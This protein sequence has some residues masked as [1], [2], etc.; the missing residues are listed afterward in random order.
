MERKLG[1]MLVKD[2]VISRDDL[3][4]AITQQETSKR[5]LGSVLIDLGLTSEWEMAAAL[6]KQ[7]NVPFIT[8]SHYEIDEL[9]L[10]SIPREIVRKYK[11]VPV[12]KTGDTLTIALADPSNIYL[13][14]ELK[15]LTKSDIIPVISFESDITEAIGRYYPGLNDDANQA[16]I[17]EALKDISDED[18]RS[19]MQSALEDDNFDM[20][21]SKEDEDE[22]GA[23]INDAPVIQLV[24]MIISEALKM[25]ASDIHIEPY[26]KKLRLRYRVDGVLHEMTNPPKKFQNAIISRIKILSELDIA[27]RRLPQDGRFRVKIQGRPI[28]FRVSTCPVI[29]GEKVVM[30]ILDQGNLML[31]LEDLGFDA[32]IKKKFE[33]A[34]LRPYG[35]CLITGPTG[36]GKST[37]LYSALSR[38]NDPSKNISTCEDP[39]EYN[40]PGINQVNARPDVGLDFAAALKSFLRQDPDIIMVGE[41]RDLETGAIAVKAALTGHLVLSTL[42][43]NDAPGTVQ[44]LLNMGI[45]DFLITA[46]LNMIQAQR[47]A[48][49]ICKKCRYEYKPD[50]IEAK[51]LGVDFNEKEDLLFYKGKGCDVCRHTGY[52]GRVGLYE[53]MVMDDPL[54]DAIMAEMPPSQFKRASIAQGMESMRQAAIKKVLQ[55]A[56]TVEQTLELTVEDPID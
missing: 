4:K 50:A 37:T 44:R 45:E 41:I 2:N 47:L 16:N 24:N 5:S 53:V 3:E 28:D 21:E 34:I 48:R 9:V 54:R 27:E 32:D 15:I 42:H 56:T 38:I 39:V 13:L 35:M 29:Y 17:N 18:M 49:R 23:E 6:G 1:E 30:R 36:S 26:E 10:N 40:L 55:G 7:L 20:E 46:S 25:G 33:D 19:A 52:K 51:V 8:L 22:D 14:D 11:I 43:T 12:D 31:N